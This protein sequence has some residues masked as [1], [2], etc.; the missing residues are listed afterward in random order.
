M[1]YGTLNNSVTPVTLYEF[2][3]EGS[4]SIFIKYGPDAQ[5]IAANKPIIGNPVPISKLTNPL[6]LVFAFCVS[7]YTFWP[8]T[9]SLITLILI[10][11]EADESK[12]LLASKITLW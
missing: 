11:T 7:T 8:V 3:P 2:P 10:P 9:E 5:L 12:I 6:M 4:I 1:A